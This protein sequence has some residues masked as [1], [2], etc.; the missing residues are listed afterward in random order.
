MKTSKN[1]GFLFSLGLSVVIVLTIIGLTG[2]LSFIIPLVVPEGSTLEWWKIGLLIVTGLFTGLIAEKVSTKKMLPFI[3]AF[4]PLWFTLSL[5]ATFWF[6]INLMF[7]P[8]ALTVLLIVFVVHFKKLWL[9][10]SELTE[11]LV[12]LASADHILEGKSAD[13]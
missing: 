10:D 6:K 12:N 5:A 8:A 13:L 1:A 9:I 7:V 3:L 11:R 2:S 4:I